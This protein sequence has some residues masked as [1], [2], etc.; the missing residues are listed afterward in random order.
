MEAEVAVV[1]GGD[2]AEGGDVEE[3]GGEGGGVVVVVVDVKL[4]CEGVKVG[5]DHCV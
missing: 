1:E 5:D 3:E 2:V 4:R